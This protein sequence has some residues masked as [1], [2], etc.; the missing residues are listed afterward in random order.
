MEWRRAEV[1]AGLAATAG[2]LAVL[3][4]RAVSQR[5]SRHGSVRAGAECAVASSSLDLI[6]NTPLVHLR[7][8]SEATGCTILAKAEFL[9]PG[10]SSK[11]R[12][13]LAIVREAEAAGR[14]LPGGTIVEATA[15][16][17]GISLALVARAC[18]YRCLLVTA[19]DTSPEKIKLIRSLGAQLEVV[20]P[21][22]I[23]NPEHPVN[24][25]RRRAAELGHGSIFCDQFENLANMRAHERTTGREVW[26]QTRGAIDA[27]VMGAGTGGT[28]AGV[29]RYVKARKPSVRVYLADPPGS[30]LYHRVVHGV[31]YTSQQQERSARRHRYDTIMEGVGC[32]RVTAN[33]AS[34]LVDG[35]FRVL[36]DE[37]VAMAR[38]LLEKEGLFVGG[39]SAMHAVAAVRAAQELGPGHTIVTVLCDGGQRYLSSVHAQAASQVQAMD[40]AEAH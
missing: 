29:S 30:A 35:A 27:F 8:L 1:T 18:G 7:S 28:I 20:K 13:A 6:G 19:D 39:S 11:D 23:A 40:A 34:A 37:S 14:L 9:N 4:V 32:D 24:V 31:L 2:L 25:A 38:L 22:S 10:G 3:A 5:R 33:F 16:S 26:E 15:G 36:D 17:T 21:A 12:V